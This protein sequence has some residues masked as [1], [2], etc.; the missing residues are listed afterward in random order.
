SMAWV[1]DAP[2]VE[3]A[4]FLPWI[5]RRIGISIEHKR[6]GSLRDT[7]GDAVVNCT[8][9]GARTL[10]DDQS[11]RAVYGGIV[12]V[13]PGMLDLTVSISDD[14]RASDRRDTDFFYSIPRRNEVV[15]GGTAEPCSDDRSLVVTDAEREGIL[16]RCRAAGLEPPRVIRCYGGLRPFRPSVRVERDPRDPRVIHNYGHGGAGYTLSWGCALDV[17][18]LVGEHA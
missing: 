18:K 8:G 14:R 3:P 17:V 9:L 1:F 4:V 10:A 6:V 5:Q 13:E 11:M 16:A 7:S 2:R 12:V 15:L